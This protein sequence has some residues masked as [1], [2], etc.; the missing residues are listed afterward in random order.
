[1]ESSPL[2]AAPAADKASFPNYA[3]FAPWVP[4]DAV[5]HAGT[6]RKWDTRGRRHRLLRRL[7]RLRLVPAHEV[8][9]CAT[10]AHG[11]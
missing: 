9:G 7:Q 10:S 3:L 11:W 2:R 4:A 8:A 1:M 6:G 5:H